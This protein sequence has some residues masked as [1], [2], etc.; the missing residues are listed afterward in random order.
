[1]FIITIFCDYFNGKEKEDKINYEIYQLFQLLLAF[2]A[3]KM[4]MIKKGR[5]K[6]SHNLT[7]LFPSLFLPQAII[8]MMI[9]MMMME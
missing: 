2:Q 6:G 9:R 3:D 1:M 7:L 5:E 8:V 4:L